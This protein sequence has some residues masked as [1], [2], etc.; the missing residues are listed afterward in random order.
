MCASVLDAVERRAAGR[1]VAR[2]GVQ[3]GA[4]LGVVADAFQQSFLIAAAGSVAEDA[5][6]ELTEVPGDE[7]VLAWI[8]YREPA[9]A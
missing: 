5:A 6:T 3:V 8:E 4:R 1:A 7:L 9:E 2:V